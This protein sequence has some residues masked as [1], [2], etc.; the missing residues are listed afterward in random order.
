MKSPCVF[1]VIPCYR[2]Q[3]MLPITAEVLYRE[4][5]SLVDRQLA[6]STSRVLFVDDG[7]TDGTWDINRGALG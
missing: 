6:S 3:E 5:K 7:S 2:E 1:I 4:M